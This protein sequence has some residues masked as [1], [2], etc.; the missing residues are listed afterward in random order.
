MALYTETQEMSPLWPEPIEHVYQLLGGG[1]A[2]ASAPK[3][4]HLGLSDILF[5][6]LIMS[7]PRERRPWGIATWMATTFMLSR[8]GLYDLTERVQERLLQPPPRVRSLPA[9][10]KLSEQRLQRTV[11]TAAFPGKMAIRQGFGGGL[12]PVSQRGMDQ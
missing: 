11:L 10:D 4:P 9:P 6:V 3:L 7:L 5:M 8:T 2:S 12:W 1:D